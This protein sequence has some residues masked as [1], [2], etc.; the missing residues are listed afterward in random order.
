[1]DQKLLDALNN[2]SFA[3]EEISV[4]LKDKKGSKSDTTTALQ[5]G[6]F[7]KT[8]NEI[9][10]GIKSI[11]KDTEK[12]LKQQKTILELSKKKQA[13]KKTDVFEGDSKKESSIKKGVSSILLIAVGVLAIGLAFKLV[14]K[15]D[16]FSV[17]ALGIGIYAVSVAFDKIGRLKDLSY[18]KVLMISLVMPLMGMGIWLASKFL[19]RVTPMSLGQI[20]TAIGVATAFYFI[21]PVITSMMDAM[22][23]TK[24]I[25]M[26]GGKKIKSSKFDM[27]RL[28]A[29]IV[30]LP[31]LMVAMAL[32]ITLSSFVLSRIKPMGL[33]QIITAIA[34]AGMFSIAA[35]GVKG[36]IHALTEENEVKGA[37]GFKTKKMDMGK[38]MKV[39]LFLPI[40][41]MAI[42]LGITLSSYI[43][44]GIKPIT[45]GKAITA[46]LIAGM[47]AVVSWGIAK[48][49]TALKDLD[50]A[51]MAQAVVMIPLLL[52]AIAL[53]ITA[54]SWVL[55]LIKPISFSQFLTGLAI[56]IMFIAFSVTLLILAK[57]DIFG[58]IDKK[59]I[60]MIPLMFAALSLAIMISSWILSASAEITFGR[61]LEILAF[62]VVM[63]I[64]VI[65]VALTALLIT[66]I[67]DVKMYIKAGVSI[68]IL[69]ATIM[70][71]SWMI[72]KG[73]YKKY[74]DWKWAL[75]VGLSLVVF[76]GVSWALMKIGSVKTYIKGAVSIIVLAGTIMVASI[77]L[78][79][80][81]YKK[82]PSAKW[83]L[84]VGLALALFGVGAVL[85]G[86][87]V[88]NPFFYGGLGAVL[89]VAGV[90]VAAS[91]ILGLGNYK[92]YPSVKWG[93]GVGLA[94]AAV[95]VGAVA[96]GT[97]VLNPFFYAGLGEI[98]LVAATVVETSHILNKG[99]YKKYPTVS[100]AGGVGLALAG[101]GL[102]A[103]LLGFNVLNPFFGSGL[104]LIK[105][106]AKTIVE[107]SH[108]LTRGAWKQA[109]DTKWAKGMAALFKEMDPVFAIISE[110]DGFMSSFDDIIDNIIKI[111]YGMVRMAK[112]FANSSSWKYPPLEWGDGVSRS[113]IS[114]VDL[115]NYVSNKLDFFAG[116]SI[117]GMVYQMATTAKIIKS[118]QRN[119]L[120]TIPETFMR[121]LAANILTYA[122]LTRSLDKILSIE[123]K[124]SIG[125]GVLGSFQYTSKRSVDLSNINR[126][127]YQMGVTA[128]IIAG[129]AK[130]MKVAINPNYMKNLSSNILAYAML[131]RKLDGILSIQEK[132]SISM[133][134]FGSIDYTSKRAVDLSSIN[135]VAYQMGITAKIVSAASKYMKENVNPN[136][137][138]NLSSNI[139]YYATLSRKLSKEQSLGSLV[140]NALFGDP[141]S[142]VAS[143]MVKLAKAYDRLSVSL[144]KL[145][146]AM[147]TLDSKKL[148]EFNNLTA[149]VAVLSSLNSTMFDN[150]LQVLESRSSVFSKI[151][152]EQSGAKGVESRRPQVGATKSEDRSS[153][154]KKG[155]HGDLNRQMDILIELMAG[156]LKTVGDGSTLDDFLQKKMGERQSKSKEK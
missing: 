137:M 54:S 35:M 25:T 28:K 42:A 150:M 45:L 106:V 32:G 55:S 40:V 146:G 30:A 38:L 34:V 138:K 84:S 63:C 142:N 76:G 14:G 107:V 69:A 83:S 50:P 88:L 129:S 71:S 61:S 79:K 4:A 59:D 143:G 85:L 132:K 113:V 135:R 96:L 86:T 87:Q 122:Y 16:F 127:A 52:P 18:K 119:F 144:R 148:R 126:V 56:S 105:K 10:V 102:G 68:A 117:R 1:M 156:V 75:S 48:M 103:V 60:V 62:S 97:Q 90:V 21:A 95:G 24:E 15:V 139:L 134:V 77:I 125:N 121:N 17:I 20:I 116:D 147:K 149:N 128:R 51:K 81:D 91:H 31:I 114:F 27:G 19:A 140:K 57:A 3:L 49:L 66:K 43:L 26:P 111:S 123:E 118:N 133:G 92:K 22:M 58:K 6:N 136:Y 9:N 115:S 78:N 11:K 44:A 8:I 89:L 110:Y 5:S 94:L 152:K 65:V 2:L 112:Q 141:I 73:T 67:G 64:A 29:T 99:N 36:L 82:Y 23:N 131:S 53:A 7:S 46:I 39:A 104:K 41:M 13:D 120:A 155:K 154:A 70:I 109:P 151:L 74:P 12:I 101:F 33:S 37:G 130:Y 145:G 153:K 108:I 72:S 124:K 98:L 93:A 47:F 80:G 100:W